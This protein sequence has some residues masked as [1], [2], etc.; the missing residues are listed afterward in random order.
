[1]EKFSIEIKFKLTVLVTA[2][3]FVVGIIFAKPTP[4]DK[5]LDMGLAVELAFICGVIGFSILPRVL[6]ELG[7]AYWKL[8]LVS[9][10]LGVAFVQLACKV[11]LSND[12]LSEKGQDRLVLYM[13]KEYG[14]L[15]VAPL[16]EYLIETIKIPKNVE[17]ITKPFTNTKLADRLDILYR[18]FLLANADRMFSETEENAIKEIAKALHIGRKRF[19]TVKNRVFTEKG[20]INKEQEKKEQQKQSWNFYMMDQLM[21]MAYNPYQ[22]LEVEQNISNEDVKK[23]Y[24]KMVKKYHPDKSMLE[25]DETRKQDALKIIEINEAYES[26]KKMRGIK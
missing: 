6:F 5:E 20:Y 4:D 12:K 19:E 17:L 21:K 22:V 1:L 13:Q 3:G 9:G 10:P 11:L 26:I 14:D 25:D 24:R 18:L 16:E 15:I 2:V 8:L 23:A 7:N